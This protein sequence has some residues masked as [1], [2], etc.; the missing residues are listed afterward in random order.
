MRIPKGG[1]PLPPKC[2][3]KASTYKYR[4]IE[5]LREF[6]HLLGNKT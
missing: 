5:F 4:D 6:L 3:P 1:T 2:E